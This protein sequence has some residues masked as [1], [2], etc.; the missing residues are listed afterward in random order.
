[1]Q[2][3]QDVQQDAFS[4]IKSMADVVKLQAEDPFRFQTWQVHQMRLQAAKAENDRVES[5]KSRKQQDEWTA[6]IN[7]QNTR[8]LELI[9]EL[10]DEAK[11]S[12]LRERVIKE[13]LPDLGFTGSELNELA[14]G[15][16]K[17]SIYDARIQRL[18]VDSLALKDIRNAPKAI[19]AKSVPPVQRPG[20]PKPPGSGPSAQ[21]QALE[22]KFN[23][24]GSL[25]DAQAL[26]AA[27][28]RL[29]NRRAS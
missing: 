7:E 17:L 14:A 28:S 4:D 5:D 27:Q 9:P 1:M 25:K 23:R 19:A 6:H 13:V 16:S 3:L 15:K 18:L 2:E 22:E 21:I 29:A 11:S 20:T 10:A 24:T 26:H 12:T 8:A